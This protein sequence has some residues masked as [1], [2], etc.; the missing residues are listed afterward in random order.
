MVITRPG[1]FSPQSQGLPT[2]PVQT[3]FMG[4]TVID[5]STAI[6]WGADS[7]TLS[8][9]LIEDD[10][11]VRPADPRVEG[12]APLVGGSDDWPYVIAWIP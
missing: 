9:N 6:G 7:S 12:Y 5:F 10:T 2:P 11:F 3:S 8:V 1:V 4:A